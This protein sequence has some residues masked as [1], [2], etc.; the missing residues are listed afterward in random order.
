MSNIVVERCGQ[1]G[2]ITLDR[3]DALNSLT[4]DMIRDIHAAIRTHEADNNVDVIVLRSSNER[5]FCAG[6]DMKVTRLQAIA[7]EWEELH[8]FFEEEYALN[9]HI[10]QCAKPYV[11]LV[12]G[13]AMGGG[14]GLSV[15]GD[16]LV[17]SETA[18]LA[19]P[20]TAIG[21]FPDVGGTHFLSRLP[22]D[23]GLWLALTGVPVKGAEAVTVG[24]AT[25]FVHSENFQILC[26]AL[27]AQGREALTSTLETLNDQLPDGVDRVSSNT[28]SDGAFITTLEQRKAWFASD[29][30]QAMI[31]ALEKAS[32]SSEDAKR[33]LDRINVVSPY[34]MA[35]TRKLLI[36]AKQHDLAACLQLELRAA[37]EAVRHPDFVEGIR[38]VL[39]DKDKAVWASV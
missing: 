18:R 7:Q 26:D 16:A 3:P 5:S 23:A 27:E 17:V 34:A 8:A 6:G 31:A 1:A 20:E 22:F 32:E 24:L 2:Y 11:S 37:A 15:H 10:G 4:H 14:L 38:A 33:L 28:I 39:V 19:M 21:F 35:L 13:I 9:L 36:E 30:Q 25:H 12:N 29:S